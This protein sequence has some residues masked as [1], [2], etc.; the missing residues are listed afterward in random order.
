MLIL[1]DVAR[2]RL[3]WSREAQLAGRRA[4]AFY[5]IGAMRPAAASMAASSTGATA[6]LPLMLVA[7]NHMEQA[8]ARPSSMVGP[9]EHRGVLMHAPAHC[10]AVTVDGRRLLWSGLGAVDVTS[11]VDAEQAGGR[12]LGREDVVSR[13]V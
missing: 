8:A 4:G 11:G 13:R 2:A 1:H 10:Q 6:L 5:L 3:T 7:D 12:P 9:S